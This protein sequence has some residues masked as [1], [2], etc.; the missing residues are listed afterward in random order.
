MALCIQIGKLDRKVT[1][2]VIFIIT[3]FVKD[4]LYSIFTEEKNNVIQFI[5]L[6]VIAK[7]FGGLFTFLSFYIL[8]S[9]KDDFLRMR[10]VH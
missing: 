7:I 3:F 6:I 9:K 5:F 10:N 8:S 1:Y 4:F 2:I